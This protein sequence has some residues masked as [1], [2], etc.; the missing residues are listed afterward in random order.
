M[1]FF[2]KIKKYIIFSNILFFNFV[3]HSFVAA[4]ELVD[5]RMCFSYERSEYFIKNRRARD[6]ISVVS[7]KCTKLIESSSDLKEN[8]NENE[9]IKKIYYSRCIDYFLSE[10]ESQKNEKGQI[11]MYVIIFIVQKDDTIK[12]RVCLFNS[13]DLNELNSWK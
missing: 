13:I 6:N 4:K 2:N 12:R 8:N 9:E 5:E 3:N 1:N 11:D 7:I 10:N